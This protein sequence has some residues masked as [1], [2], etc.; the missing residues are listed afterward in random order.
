MSFWKRLAA[1][2]LESGAQGMERQRD[3]ANKILE[4]KGERLT[5]EQRQRIESYAYSDNPERARDI[6]KGLRDDE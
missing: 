5:D 2:F 3:Y 4:T 6:A 1:S